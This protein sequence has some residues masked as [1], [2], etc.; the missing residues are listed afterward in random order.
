[1]NKGSCSPIFQNDEHIPAAVSLYPD[2]D[3]LREPE[4]HLTFLIL[5]S[6]PKLEQTYQE[7]QA[8]A[9]MDDSERQRE[10]QKRFEAL[11]CRGDDGG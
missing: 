7:T 5:P 11:T 1:M 4:R 2:F 9:E 8:I 3:R 10:E 6:V